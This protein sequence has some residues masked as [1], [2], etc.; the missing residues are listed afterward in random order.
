MTTSMPMA[1]YPPQCRSEDSDCLELTVAGLD[2][3]DKR[4]IEFLFIGTAFLEPS[5]AA[6]TTTD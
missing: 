1:R 6:S 3:L 4:M 2:T 5:T